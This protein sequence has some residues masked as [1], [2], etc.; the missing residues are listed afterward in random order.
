M[1][2][3]PETS[4]RAIA[5]PGTQSIMECVVIPV[6]V[7][8]REGVAFFQVASLGQTHSGVCWQRSL[9]DAALGVGPQGS[10]L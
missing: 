9:V 4:S 2:R 5:A 8:V 7:G 1:V 6:H 3:P 10:E